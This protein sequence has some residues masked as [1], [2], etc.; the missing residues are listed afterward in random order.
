[1][2]T[3]KDVSKKSGYSITTVSRALNDY[4]DI[5]D[6]TKEK[7]LRTAEEMGF[8]PNSSARSLV[9][10]KSYTI[11]IIFQEVSGLGLQHPLFSKVL[12]DFKSIVEQEGYDVIFLSR[13]IGGQNGSYLQHSL[14]KQ[15]EGVFILCADFNSPEMVELYESDLPMVIIDFEHKNLCNITSNNEDGV[16]QA[17][18]YLKELGHKKIANIHGGKKTYIGG[19]RILFFEQSMAKAGL[20]INPD[21]MVEGQFFS[22]EEG[23]RAMQE[24]MKLPEQPSAIFCASDMMAIGAI[25]AIMEAGKKVPEDY[26]IIGFDGTDVGQTIHPRLTTVK[27]DT[28]KISAIAASKILKMIDDKHKQPVGETIMVDAHLVTG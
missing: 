22:K 16:N 27:Q 4:P 7:I 21:F 2:V 13:R 1:M 20:E 6:V 3:I 26:S 14:R 11:G 5:S 24:I 8:V 10:Q 18:T 23:Y 15:V 12:E 17:I 28:R 19:Q 25:Q 9:T